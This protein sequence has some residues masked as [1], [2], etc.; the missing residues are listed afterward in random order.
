MMALVILVVHITIL[1]IRDTR[2]ATGV[3][4]WAQVR[5]WAAVRSA[6]E[7][8]RGQVWLQMLRGTQGCCAAIGDLGEGI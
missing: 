4:G 7:T 3:A 1:A 5:L 6:G 8:G 2:R